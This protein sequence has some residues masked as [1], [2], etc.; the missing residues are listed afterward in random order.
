MKKI[1]LLFILFCTWAGLNAEVKVGVARL[2]ITPDTAIWMSGYAS[3]NKPSEGV[4]QDLW[5]KALAIE[6]NSSSRV[7]I[8]TADIIGLPR[9]I[10]EEIAQ[11][12][13]EKYGISRSQL[14]INTSHTHSGPVIW[15]GLIGMYDLN[16]VNLST[17]V[18]YSGKL[19]DDFVDVVGLALADLTPGIISA[20]HGSADFAV[21][22]RQSTDNGVIIGV[23]P[24]GPVDH[25]VPVVKFET[26]DGRMK[27]VLFGYACHNTTLNDYFISG[28]YAGFA[29]AE[30]ERSYPGIVAM[31]MEGCG[32][33]QNPEPRRS[34]ELAEK[35]GKSLAYAVQK[36]LEGKLDPVRP[37]IRTAFTVA[38]L[39]FISF[40][41]SRYKN[42]LLEGDRYMKT[43]ASLM[44]EAW[45][46]GYDVTR[47]PYPVQAVR[48]NKD[49]T[50][51]ALSGEVV[52]DYSL[53][54]K[55]LYPGENL[56]VAGYSNE[57]PCYVPSRRVLNEGG[58][59][60]VTSMIY[61]GLPGPFKDNVE[62]KVFS[63]IRQVMKNTGAKEKK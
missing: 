23:N 58:Y 43:R 57:V 11:R 18:R 61:Y 59:E 49:L 35:H 48:F 27:A 31:F 34:V 54:A 45:E 22:R 52:V 42:E 26:P 32:A 9:T 33:D 50:I 10:Y 55:K 47:L 17:V 15:P 6:E 1:L 3:R 53:A 16:S 28:D 7:V 2:K 20:G 39:E 14:L 60:P 62:D 13:T 25:D 63:A 40:D 19:S 56:F 4:M 24:V 5:V 51:L 36:V 29:Q 12:I 46:R 37:P 41:P 38:D 30:L 44:L 8:V 21:N